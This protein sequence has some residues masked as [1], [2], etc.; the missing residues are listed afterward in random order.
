MGW[1]PNP[2]PGACG[3][4]LGSLPPYPVAGC[5]LIPSPTVPICPLPSRSVWV[6]E[7]A[8]PSGLWKA[9][10][11]SGT[12]FPKH[13]ALP[14]SSLPFPDPTCA[15]GHVASSGPPPPCGRVVPEHLCPLRL[16]PDRSRSQV[17]FPSSGVLYQE[18]KSPECLA[19]D[20]S[21]AYF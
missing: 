13:P 1:R 20:T 18:D 17:G 8:R 2:C 10:C 12:L 4:T 5:L 6:L 15:A 3:L 9:V 14:V 16:Q 19:L 21:R 7:P 11:S